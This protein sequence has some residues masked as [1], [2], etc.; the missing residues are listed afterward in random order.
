MQ[1]FTRCA[2]PDFDFGTNANPVDFLTEDLHEK[3]I[4]L[5]AAV[6]ADFVAEQTSGN[7][8]ARTS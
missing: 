8:D 4:A 3:G 2:H 1:C 7:A 5:V 6:V